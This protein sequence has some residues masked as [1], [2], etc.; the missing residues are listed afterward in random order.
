M[1]ASAA[2]FKGA[3]LC[4]DENGKAEGTPLYNAMAF[5]F[6][7]KDKACKACGRPLYQHGFVKTEEKP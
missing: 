7:L 3:I 6:H 4:P 2:K 5:P 1:N